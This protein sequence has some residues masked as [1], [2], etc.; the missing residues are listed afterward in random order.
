MDRRVDLT[1]NPP[2]PMPAVSVLTTQL[3]SRRHGYRYLPSGT[4]GLS[5]SQ[6][7]TVLGF[8]YQARLERRQTFTYITATLRTTY[9]PLARRDNACLCFQRMT[10]ITREVTRILVF[11]R[12]R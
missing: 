2:A 9:S 5:P 7:K 12:R 1:G 4:C 6:A 8:M 11:V 10:E 3:R